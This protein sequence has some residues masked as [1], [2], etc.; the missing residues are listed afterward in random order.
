MEEYFNKLKDK[1]KE[2]KLNEFWI[3]SDRTDF[4]PIKT[5]SEKSI[6]KMLKE[7]SQY[8]KN[9]HICNVKLIFKSN[10]KFSKIDDEEWIF[11]IKSF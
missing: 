7:K 2:K 3:F 10:I 9:K 4:K 11:S 8:Y 1:I 6:K 5:T